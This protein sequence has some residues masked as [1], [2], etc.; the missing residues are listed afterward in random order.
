M[1]YTLYEA[2]LEKVWQVGTEITNAR[3]RG[4]D[5]E[6]NVSDLGQV[7]TARYLTLDEFNR[8]D[9]PLF[10]QDE[11]IYIYTYTCKAKKER[12][13][14]KCTY[15]IYSCMVIRLYVYDQR[16]YELLIIHKRILDMYSVQG[17]EIHMYTTIII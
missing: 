13:L 6:L 17:A 2:E 15:Y 14:N 8:R 16:R 1:H 12:N 4:I 7:V 3:G 5:R 10:N 9:K 11:I